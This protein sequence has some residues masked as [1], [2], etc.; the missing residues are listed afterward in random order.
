MSFLSM[1]IKNKDS[2]VLELDCSKNLNRH[3]VTGE[4][5]HVLS[6]FKRRSPSAYNLRMM[7]KGKFIRILEHSQMKL[8]I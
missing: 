1:L 8:L 7:Q 2:R 4:K 3:S 5:S 6:F